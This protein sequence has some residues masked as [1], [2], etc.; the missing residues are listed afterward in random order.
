M[1]EELTPADVEAYTQGRLSASDPETLRALNA[2][3]TRARRY[4]GWHVS[5]VRQDVAVLDRPSWI[6]IWNELALPTLKVVSLDGIEIDGVAM[7][8]AN[9]RESKEAPGIIATKDGRPW[10]AGSLLLYDSGYGAIEVTFTHGYA[11]A[12]AEDFRSAVL[13]LVD[14]AAMAAEGENVGEGALVEKEV[15]DVRYKWASKVN[16][17]SIDSSALQ[18]FRIL[19]L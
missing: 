15:D 3:L 19:A 9:V 11:A 16:T 17:V 1:A 10:G 2:A 8:L 5:P 6:G 12:D 14:R 4:C 18:S 7:D 13:A